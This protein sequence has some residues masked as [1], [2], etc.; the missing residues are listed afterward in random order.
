[1]QVERKGT[2]AKRSAAIRYRPSPVKIVKKRK[3]RIELG[4][5]NT[6]NTNVLFKNPSI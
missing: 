6:V 1:M 2:G 3:N 5:M 4:V